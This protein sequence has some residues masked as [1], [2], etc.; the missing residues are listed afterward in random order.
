MLADGTSNHVILI[1]VPHLHRGGCGICVR[2][3][4]QYAPSL[5]PQPEMQGDFQAEEF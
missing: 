3:A 1:S 4:D 5:L 2:G